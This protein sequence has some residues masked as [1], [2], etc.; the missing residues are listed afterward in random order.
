MQL[1]Y[2]YVYVY[3]YTH[4]HIYIYNG[5][6][7]IVTSW[8]NHNDRCYSLSLGKMQFGVLRGGTVEVE[9]GRAIDGNGK[10]AIKK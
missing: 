10:N 8:N 1:Y 5:R 4:T 7:A 9:E 2:V 6:I 3:I